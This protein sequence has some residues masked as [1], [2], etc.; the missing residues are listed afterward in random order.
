MI[1]Q[2]FLFIHQE[3][4]AKQ[5][6]WHLYS[7]VE[8]ERRKATES[9][10][11]ITSVERRVVSMQTE[12]SEYRSALDASD[13]A[14]KASENQLGE[15]TDRVNE[16]SS[17]LQTT[18]S[19]KRRLEADISAMR[20]DLEEMSS[21]MRRTDENAKKFSLDANRLVEELRNEK[22]RSSQIEKSRRI[23]ETQINELHIHITEVESRSSKGGKGVVAQL[24]ARVG[25]VSN[26][27]YGY[28]S[29]K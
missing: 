14:R 1:S 6:Y 4:N 24:S 10:E 8:D 17:Q 2:Y 22:D 20:T 19:A 3:L 29:L 7:F 26:D 23:L 27:Q 15:A 9:I 16:L 28:R 5:I 21:E 11:S 25:V 13:R 18:L 12:C